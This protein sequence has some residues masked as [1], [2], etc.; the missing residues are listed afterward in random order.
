MNG[1]EYRSGKLTT[2]KVWEGD[3]NNRP[4][5]IDL[6]TA[7]LAVAAALLHSP[8]HIPGGADPM[9]WTVNK[10]LLGGGAGA[11]PTEVDLAAEGGEG[12]PAISIYF[13]QK[14]PATGVGTTT[15]ERCNDNI[16]N[17]ANN[18]TFG[19]VGHSIEIVFDHPFIMNE[20]R[21]YGNSVFNVNDVF[22]VQYKNMEDTYV[23][24]ITGLVGRTNTWSDWDSS[25][26]AVKCIGLRMECTAIVLGLKI[27]EI[28]VRY[29]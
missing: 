17:D 3:A 22:K 15:P 7:V 16:V 14:N 23:D 13:L 29:V 8:R 27:G 2:D 1:L 9:R 26:G 18:S 4:A 6:D 20:F 11:D 28:E 25:G 19:A 21:Y 12:Y 24:W 5:E 10:L